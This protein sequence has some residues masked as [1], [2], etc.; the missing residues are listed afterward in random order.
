MT[1]RY[2]FV[3]LLVYL[4]YGGDCMEKNVIKNNIYKKIG[5]FVCIFLTAFM[6]A[7]N[8]QAEESPAVYISIEKFVLGQGYIVE[9]RKY[10]IEPNEKVSSVLE[11]FC[12]QEGIDLV[13]QRN[14]SYGW[15]LVGIENADSGKV[16]IPSCLMN[17]YKNVLKEYMKNGN[18]VNGIGEGNNLEEFCYTPFSG[19]L[20]FINDEWQFVGMSYTNMKDGDVLR[21]KYTIVEGDSGWSMGGQQ[22]ISL[23]NHNNLIKYLA[24]IHEQLKSE[25]NEDL[26]SIYN[27]SIK[28]AS[29][30]DAD[31][32]TIKQIEGML[33]SIVENQD[34][35]N[36]TIENIKDQVQ[37]LLQQVQ[38]EEFKSQIA[39]LEEEIT[40]EDAMIIH[41]AREIYDQLTDIQKNELDRSMID[42]LEQAEKALITI[43]DQKIADEV[44]KM[45]DSIGTVTL[46][47]E[48]N[49]LN[50]RNAYN[51]LSLEQKK[52]VSEE[53]VTKLIQAE[54][55]LDLL[56]TKKDEQE[57]QVSEQVT[58][59][60]EMQSEIQQHN[61]IKQ[62][63]PAKT[64]LKAVKKTGTKKAKLTWKKVKAASGYEIYMSTKKSSGYKKIKTI[65]K[66]K[67]VTFTK[68]GLKKKKTYYFKVR[69]YRTANGV[70]YYGNY[71]NV[72]KVKIK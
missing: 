28:I 12:K 47:S 67:T 53:N 10:Y 42:K 35:D 5:V 56:K 16:N 40:L 9:P 60:Q 64:T 8:V 14:S 6:I 68:S 3:Y 50:A 20:Y 66:A 15:Y 34:L 7:K 61:L 46:S 31:R 17:N 21:L 4:S 26:Q 41:T 58:T 54:K 1:N 24:E 59:I 55:Q 2:A 37:K 63:T 49:I 69:T 36:E 38:F 29:N 23:P 30:L 44:I 48:K 11:R 71:S 62:N 22:Q 19:W 13:I 43:H 32:E 65:K 52:L 57:N 45:I 33:Q 72:K 51:S 70:T 25:P 39:L 27:L 18:L